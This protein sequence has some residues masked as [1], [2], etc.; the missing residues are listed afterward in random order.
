MPVGYNS[1]GL[2]KRITGWA[3]GKLRS[4]DLP[5]LMETSAKQSR[6]KTASSS[7]PFNQRFQKPI[8]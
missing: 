1:A 8:Q 6:I 5:Q 2:K 3:G 7:Q 4:F